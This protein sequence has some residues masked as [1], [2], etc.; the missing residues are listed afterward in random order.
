MVPTWGSSA[1]PY[2]TKL[3]P[4]VAL[5]VCAGIIG[6]LGLASRRQLKGAPHFVFVIKKINASAG[7]KTQS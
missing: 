3:V 7:Y 1:R 6:F 5:R 2:G 4:D